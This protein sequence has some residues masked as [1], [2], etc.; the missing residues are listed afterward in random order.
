MIR[1]TKYHITYMNQGE[2]K[3][4]FPKTIRNVKRFISSNP[5]SFV[6]CWKMT[7]FRSKSV[8]E[9]LFRAV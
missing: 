1:E 2:L 5:N 4:Y 3:H 7:Q 8:T 6:A 9:R